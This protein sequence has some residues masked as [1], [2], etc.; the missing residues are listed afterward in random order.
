MYQL[1]ALWHRR[2][3][4]AAAAVHSPWAML[5]VLDPSVQG[6]GTPSSGFTFGVN[7]RSSSDPCRGRGV[8]DHTVWHAAALPHSIPAQHRDGLP[9]VGRITHFFHSSSLAHPPTSL[10]IPPRL[11]LELTLT[12]AYY[13]F[14]AHSLQRKYLY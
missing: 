2:R 10:Q 7:T 13:L 4:Q 1:P 3:R 6:T 11:R 12:M 5:R 9:W 14:P 8:G